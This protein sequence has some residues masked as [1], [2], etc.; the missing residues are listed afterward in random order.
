MNFRSNLNALRPRGRLPLGTLSSGCPWQAT[1]TA[2][3]CAGISIV[4]K[5][6]NKDQIRGKVT[7]VNWQRVYFK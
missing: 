2:R 3:Q 6:M 1:G 5:G 4:A 7:R